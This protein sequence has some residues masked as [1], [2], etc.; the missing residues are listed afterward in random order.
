MYTRV[1][2]VIEFELYGRCARS[3]GWR[4]RGE[5]SPPGAAYDRRG[6]KG[7]LMD[8]PYGDATAAFTWAD[9]M[10]VGS[11]AGADAACCRS[12]TFASFTTLW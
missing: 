2:P 12:E 10:L 6:E 7:R 5:L 1:Q 11:L 4:S 3:E 9:V 8:S